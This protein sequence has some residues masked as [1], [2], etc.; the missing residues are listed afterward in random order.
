MGEKRKPADLP[1]A[2]PMLLALMLGASVGCGS[3]TASRPLG[4]LWPTTNH[5]SSSSSG[6]HP[7]REQKPVPYTVYRAPQTIAQPSDILGRIQLLMYVF[8][9]GNLDLNA[10]AKP[11]LAAQMG[12]TIQQFYAI[13]AIVGKAYLEIDQVSPGTLGNPPLGSFRSDLALAIQR[14]MA[15]NIRQLLGPKA[16]KRV[17]SWLSFQFPTWRE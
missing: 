12:I 6:S 7:A 17:S 4:L 11:R 10:K 14:Q 16:S 3:T 13:A 8:R 2:L 1:E 9:N 5:V 15:T